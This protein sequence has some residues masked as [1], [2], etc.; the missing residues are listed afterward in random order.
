MTSFI[1][2]TPRWREQAIPQVR[3]ARWLAVSRPPLANK[4][5][6]PVEESLTLARG[7]VKKLVENAK[8]VRFLDANYRDIFS[9]FDRR[10]QGT[11]LNLFHRSW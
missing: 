9:E 8:A 4:S 10:V 11:F 1:L 3:E 7:Y 2:G 6:S 5:S